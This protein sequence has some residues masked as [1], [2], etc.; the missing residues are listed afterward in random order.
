MNKRKKYAYIV[1]CI[2]A[3]LLGVNAKNIRKIVSGHF[4]TISSIDAT[5][6]IEKELKKK[7]PDKTFEWIAGGY[8]DAKGYDN[9]SCYTARFRVDNKKDCMIYA[10]YCGEKGKK[11]SVIISEKKFERK[12]SLA[13]RLCE[14]YTR[15]LNKPIVK[16]INKYN[17]IDKISIVS[18][19]E[20]ADY[21]KPLPEK[22]DYE[23]EFAPEL[24]LDWEMKLI[25]NDDLKHYKNE[26]MKE[27]VQSLKENGMEFRKYH[28][29]WVKGAERKEYVYEEDGTI[30]L[31]GVE[32]K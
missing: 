21:E 6:E 30:I 32:N 4:E 22:Y 13:S 28:F 14:D 1:I 17:F 10:T 5:K 7:Y 11:P 8:S 27:I 15:F 2:L 20:H 9:D 16:V 12:C 29:V 23:M 26:T 31:K 18:P 3:V 25:V 19:Y 24:E